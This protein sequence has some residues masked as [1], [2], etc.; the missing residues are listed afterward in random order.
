MFKAM[1]PIRVSAAMALGVLVL[2]HGA[3]NADSKR[4][5]VERQE[6]LNKTLQSSADAADERSRQQRGAAQ[7]QQERILYL[8]RRAQ[9]QQL[10]QRCQ[11]PG[12]GC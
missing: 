11:I 8:A 2:A 9:R 1:R 10:K 6:Q 5:A 7:S 4:S 12:S 3:A